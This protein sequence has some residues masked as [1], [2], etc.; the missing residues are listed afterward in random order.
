MTYLRLARVR[1]DKKMDLNDERENHAF[2][3]SDPTR[4]SDT[5]QLVEKSKLPHVSVEEGAAAETDGTS[6]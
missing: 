3:R 4:R 6:F 1:E 5:H 2:D